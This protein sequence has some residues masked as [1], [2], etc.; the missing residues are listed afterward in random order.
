MNYGFIPDVYPLFI[1][2][3]TAVT[4]TVTQGSVREAYG[5]SLIFKSQVT[6]RGE[7]ATDSRDRTFV[8]LG[9]LK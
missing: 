2:G 1:G 5:F 8:R 9:K 7:P 6:I 4:A 3:V